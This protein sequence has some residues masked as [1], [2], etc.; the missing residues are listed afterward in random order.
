MRNMPTMG[1][2]QAPPPLKSPGEKYEP[3]PEAP[4]VSEIAEEPEA[5]TPTGIEAIGEEFGLDPA[6]TR[7]FAAKFMRH[8]MTQMGCGGEEVNESET[9]GYPE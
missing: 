4:E 5:P 8:M 9:E 6:S 7:Q 1:A 3:E 2:R